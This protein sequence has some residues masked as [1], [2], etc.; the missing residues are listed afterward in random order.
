MPT[1][2][3]VSARRCEPNEADRPTSG[4]LTVLV[5][6]AGFEIVADTSAIQRWSSRD[7]DESP[8]PEGCFSMSSLADDLVDAGQLEVEAERDRSRQSTKP[9]VA[10]H[11]P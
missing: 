5:A 1:S 9:P 4:R 11:A 7:P 2:A 10:A 8:A 6:D 3:G